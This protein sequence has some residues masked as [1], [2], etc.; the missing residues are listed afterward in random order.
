M[1]DMPNDSIDITITSP[2]YNIGLNY[3][4]YEDNIS[5]DEYTRFTTNWLDVLYSITKETGRLYC[6]LDDR[7][8]WNVKPI[9]ES[10]GW[11]Y[12]Q[13]LTWN[14]P[15]F[16][17]KARFSG[18]WNQMTEYVLLLRKGKSTKMLNP[19]DIEVTTHNWFV[20]TAPQSNFK[21]DYQ[22]KVHPAQMPVNLIRKWI[23]RTP[24]QVVLDPFCG[25]GSVCIAA[26]EL[27]RDYIGIDISEDYCMLAIERLLLTSQDIN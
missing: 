9:A 2:P 15:N 1:R 6:V 13:L 17:G 20:E 11:K 19:R 3:D 4:T 16:A 10:I 21:N 24:G 5:S 26:K 23:S 18:D 27:G 7:L 22:K 25:A 14:K 12:V 8:I